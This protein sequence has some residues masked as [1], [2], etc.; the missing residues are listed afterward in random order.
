MLFCLYVPYLRMLLWV[1]FPMLSGGSTPSAFVYT[2]QRHVRQPLITPRFA[3]QIAPHRVLSFGLQ[4]YSCCC[5]TPACLDLLSPLIYRF[6]TAL[7]YHL[8][9]NVGHLRCCSIDSRS[10]LQVRTPPTCHT[11]LCCIIH[12]HL[13]HCY[14]LVTLLYLVST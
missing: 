11:S 12:S 7:F 10:V 4:S 3:L 14:T 6:F 8:D 9:G 5:H 13:I 1:G 2:M